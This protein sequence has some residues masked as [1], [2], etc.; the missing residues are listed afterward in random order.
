MKVRIQ[1]RNKDGEIVL[2]QTSGNDL[3]GVLEIDNCKPWWPYL[4]NPE[5]GYL[6]HMEIFLLINDELLDIYRLKVGIRTLTW[7]ST[8]FLING[9]PIYF[10]GF[11]KHEDS[12]VSY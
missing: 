12:D 8:S 9:K 10:R 11:G 3:K 4:M 1:L 2:N 7:N 6:Y 5:P